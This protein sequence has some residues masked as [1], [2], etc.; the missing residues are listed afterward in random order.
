LHHRGKQR[1]PLDRASLRQ[2][3]TNDVLQGDQSTLTTNA[4]VVLSTHLCL[5][6]ALVSA[7]GQEHTSTILNS[8][9]T[10]L[11]LNALLFGLDTLHFLTSQ[12]A[13][14]AG[15]NLAS[16]A[17]LEQSLLLRTLQFHLASSQ[18]R[19]PGTLQYPMK[20]SVVD[21]TRPPVTD[22]QFST[23][24][25]PGSVF[26]NDFTTQSHLILRTAWAS[27]FRQFVDAQA[28]D[29]DSQ[30]RDWDFQQYHPQPAFSMRYIPNVLFTVDFEFLIFVSVFILIK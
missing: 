7:A 16:I 29:F 27:L 2:E 30:S 5:L 20:E 3:C 18:L 15:L 12:A 6:L 26:S 8:S 10:Q 24:F 14:I 21:K 11:E 19:S 1:T 9:S 22:R 28:K 23:Y 17:I 25:N 4:L 13:V